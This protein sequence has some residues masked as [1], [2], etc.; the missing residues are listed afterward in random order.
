MESLNR[1]D[2]FE[3]PLQGIS[4][5][6]ASAGTG[7]T[8]NI[9]SLYVRAIIERNLTPSQILVMTFTEAA[10][11][12]LKQRLR[13]RMRESLAAVEGG[14]DGD[15]DFLLTLTEKEYPNAKQQLKEAIDSFDEAA[16]FTIH[17]FCNRVLAEYSLQF[18]VPA[19][20]Q[21][22]TDESEL[23]QDQVDAYWRSFI[24]KDLQTRE[25]YQLLDFLTDEGFGPD[26][27]M[28]G[29]QAVMGQSY[30]ILEPS[31]PDLRSLLD[32][33]TQLN[34]THEQAKKRW[35][36]EKAEFREVLLS[37]D[38]NG[39]KFRKN[40]LEH[41][42]NM[43][44]EW[45]ATD[46]V[47]ISIPN[48][49]DKYGEYFIDGAGTKKYDPPHFKFMDHIQ[50]FLVL[51]AQLQQLKP[52]FVI[53]S[54]SRILEDVERFKKS[55]NLLSY[56][57]LIESVDKGLKR[58]ASGS[59]AKKLS[60]KYPL[61]LVDE[62]QD[63]DPVQYSIF[64]QMYH[65]RGGT[66]LF[67]IGD[68]KQ[69][70]YGFRGGDIYTYLEAR[71]DADAGQA[72]SLQD[73]Y[74][75]NPHMISAVNAVFSLSDHPFKLDDLIFNPAGHPKGKDSDSYLIDISG[76]EIN[77]LQCITLSDKETN[78]SDLSEKIILAVCDEIQNVLKGDFSLKDTTGAVRPVKEK[79]I[80]ILVREARHGDLLQNELR[81]RG[82]S[83]V[84]KSKTSVFKT[85]Q[86][87][88]LLRVL[89]AIQKPGYE[90][91]IR[92]A[93]STS[94]LGY[95]AS[96]LINLLEDETV[97]A[98][99][100]EGF[101]SLKDTWQH[102]GIEALCNRLFNE[103]GVLE[104][105]ANYPDAERRI[106][107]LYHLSDLLSAAEKEQ[108][109]SGKTLLKWFF[110]KRQEESGGSE[111]EQLRLESDEDLVQISTMHSA[112]GLQFP[113]VFCPF[114]W[115]PPREASKSNSP[116][117]FHKAGE[118]C[119]ELMPKVEH[120]Q[121]EQFHRL[122]YQQT[123]AEDVR[124]AYVS[125]TRSISACYMVVP[126]FNKIG[127]SALATLVKGNS[128]TSVDYDAIIRSLQ[129]CDKVECRPPIEPDEKALDQ[130]E[131]QVKELAPA[132][133]FSR[134]DVFDYP[135]MLSYSSLYGH[136]DQGAPSEEHDYDAGE[137]HLQE[138][139]NTMDPFG[140]PRGAQAGTCLHKIFEDVVFSDSSTVK[141]AV[142]DNLEYHGFSE[143]W[144]PPVLKWIRN[145][146]DHPLN[147][148][149]I[150]LAD[151]NEPSV[152]KEMEFYFPVNNLQPSELWKII[153]GTAPGF[154]DIET[155]S[156][157][158]KGFVDL[159]FEAGG[160]YYI[161]DYK[162]N[163]LGNTYSDYS[164]EHIQ[165]EM[166]SAGYDLQYHIYTLA[167]HRFLSAR[168]KNYN[169]EKH[170]GGVMYLFLR[171]IEPGKEGSG[172]YFDK[173][174]TS[175]VTAMNEYLEQGVK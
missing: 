107:N 39:N 101:L 131:E 170:F 47:K 57:D 174:D 77:P 140:F 14:Y 38:L 66:G 27:L 20:F 81:S 52:A 65:Q 171:G 108:K 23:I 83:S 70:I 125:L 130:T 135:R 145:S 41:D 31:S 148:Q 124:L 159:I 74:R 165:E 99:I 96:D 8:H 160:K 4:L 139:P 21:L 46:P 91:G 172:V 6:E 90:P 95:Q 24:R 111:E 53:A 9:T 34:E 33:L 51:S 138:P 97:W 37:G 102:R 5:V 28:V 126:N 88:E 117:R 119:L 152:L 115:I 61:A 162:S 82:I 118:N 146:L 29:V 132:R 109:L 32:L 76:D 87:D 26:E 169:Y 17:G 64:R 89:K 15:D 156:G 100:I 120:A 110:T 79:D 25:D 167:V 161:L 49:L 7:K 127:D 155:V 122:H 67:M 16:V 141:E 175:L 168:K 85:L 56:N 129:E 149:G 68:P 137:E 58:D 48:R 71:S 62:F 112:K 113:I 116:I 72:Y 105:L 2:V 92:A 12:E 30:A 13:R 73:N 84:L 86:A 114:L 60:Q 158:M 98:D 128:E 153:R 154:S 78:K 63:T 69:A 36:K 133:K 55:H 44:Q 18:D 163:H 59:L 3:A 173:P 11:A 143:K 80:A 150:R 136:Q 142:E 164:A 22:L 147:T 121:S 40:Y 93:L 94:M 54:I 45:M 123:Q 43:L 104:N 35:G 1:L 166:Q 134:E 103:Y 50:D 42:L 157:F 19:E 144:I 75:S 10:T 106:T 151:L